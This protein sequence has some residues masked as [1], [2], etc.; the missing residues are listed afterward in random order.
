MLWELLSTR[1]FSAPFWNH[2]YEIILGYIPKYALHQLM[3]DER[4]QN[5]VEMMVIS[6]IDTFCS[7]FNILQKHFNDFLDKINA[8]I[9]ETENPVGIRIHKHFIMKITSEHL[10]ELSWEN[11]IGKLQQALADTLPKEAL[12]L[13]TILHEDAKTDLKKGNESLKLGSRTNPA[14]AKSLK[15]L[16][17]LSYM[18]TTFISSLSKHIPLK[19]SLSLAESFLE[20]AKLANQFNGNAKLRTDLQHAGLY[21]LV[22]NLLLQEKE[23]LL[24]YLTLSFEVYLQNTG[25]KEGEEIVSNMWR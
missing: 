6:V 23:A 1:N 18:R 9:L 16:N 19:T 11:L 10:Q 15:H 24:A 12:E 2:L 13:D 7:K 20:S 14:V 8:F 22:S 17:L 5:V 3:E 4:Y 25:N 21:A